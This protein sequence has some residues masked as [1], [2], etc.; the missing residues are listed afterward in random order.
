MN[1]QLKTGLTLL[2][3]PLVVAPWRRF[4]RQAV[5]F[6]GDFASWNEAS[7]HA[8]GY[9]SQEIVDRV[10]S[11]TRKVLAGEAA[12][13][14][15]SVVFDQIEYSWPLLASLLQVAVE[16][17]RLRV[18]DFG[19]ALGSTW[20][21]NRR[22]LERLQIPLAWHVVEQQH[23]V[24]I[25][26]QEFSSEVLRFDR[27]IAEAASGGTDVVLL[28]SSLCYVSDAAQILDEAAAT[29]AQYLI[30]DR[31]PI[32]AGERDRIAVQSVAEPI[33]SAS[34]P[35]RMFAEGPLL[36][37]LLRPWRLIERWECDLQPDPRSR[38][39]GFFLARR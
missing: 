30:I 13:E 4:F 6:S 38:C 28:S 17:Q 21:Q 34:Y 14:R 22:Y 32:V 33:Y 27:T 8:G 31:L 10:A 26:R 35:I 37:N 36:R 39:H 19:G 12:Y 25:G 1:R 2:L 7:A 11:A 15:D 16:R 3:P 18:I 23:F 29:T 20:R 9:D 24:T 5:S